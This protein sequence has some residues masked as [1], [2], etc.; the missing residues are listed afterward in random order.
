MRH[1]SDN[2]CES[3]YLILE[4]LSEIRVYF[5]TGLTTAAMPVQLSVGRSKNS[6][7]LL[8]DK[9]ARPVP[10]AAEELSK[11]SEMMKTEVAKF[12]EQVRAA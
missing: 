3:K 8:V 10:S 2:G 5:Q 11:Q 6:P 1:R 12:L 4:M 7:L 9:N